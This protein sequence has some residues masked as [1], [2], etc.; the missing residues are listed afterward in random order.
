MGQSAAV[1]IGA[2]ALTVL[3]GETVFAGELVLADAGKTAYSIVVSSAADAGTRAV[4]ED[5]AGILGEMTGATFPVVTDDMPAGDRE[6]VLGADNARLA[7]LGLSGLA[8]GFAEGEYEIRTAGARL[9]IAGAP[10]RGTINGM[11]GF[12]QDHLG[13]RWFTPG[14]QYVPQRAAVKL[15]EIRDRQK[16]A[17]R[18][19]STD[20]AAQ[21]D[22]NW[23]IRNRLNESKAGV[24]GG[25][26]AIA[27]VHGDPRSVGMAGCWRPH[28]LGDVPPLLFGKHP[29]FF[30]ELGGK[31][32]CDPVAHRRA[33]CVTNPEFAQWVAGWTKRKLRGNPQMDF[34]SI[35]HADNPNYCRCDVCQASYEEVGITGTYIRFGNRV[36]EGVAAEFPDA[37]IVTLAYG[38]TFPPT[39]VEVHPNLRVCWCP[40]GA[41]Y[42]HPLDTGGVNRDHDFVGQLKRWQAKSTQLG[43]WYYQY[44]SDNMMPRPMLYPTRRNLQIFRD[45]G[46]DQ[47]FIEMNFNNFKTKETGDG[48]KSVPAYD[49]AD[50]YGWH[51][52]PY[53]LEHVRSYIY[54]RLLWN[55]E[56]DIAA[57]IREFCDVYYGAAGADVNE[58]LTILESLDAYD[59]TMGAAFKAYEGV[60]MSLSQAPRLRWDRTQQLDKLLDEAGE[61]VRDDP[62]LLRRVEMAR[63]PLDLSILVFAGPDDPL[64]AKAFDCF[65][66]TA[67]AIGLK[68]V[69]RT[70]V[71]EPSLAL[72]GLKALMS[73]PTKLVIPGQEP[74]GANVLKNSD[75]E[76][77]IDADGIPD[78]WSAEGRYLPEGYDCD[79][80]GVHSVSTKAYSGT[81]CV[82]LV[83][84]P[85]AM[86]TVS[87]RQRFDVKPGEA[88]RAGIR[89]Q[90]DLKVGGLYMIF[91]AFDKDGTWL[92]HQGG[93]RGVKTTGDRWAELTSDNTVDDRTAQLM[94]EVLIYDDRAEGR[95]WIDDFECARIEK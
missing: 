11:Y 37:R 69:K 55:P 57:G 39:P 75:F 35:T 67:E 84:K 47:V 5:L 7:I 34:V 56:F 59:K 31:R 42:V 1:L 29:E 44:Q 71:S 65:F 21:W 46:V 78:G 12:L 53:G 72:A 66:G 20:S 79:P 76:T 83:K 60:H 19:R 51:T 94:V 24:A 28:A 89:Y 48:D 63:M 2:A 17:F 87:L 95:A 45:L 15:G 61:K 9:V 22:A 82:Q 18:W 62:M 50:R 27:Q 68:S 16:P 92:Y 90:S 36:A 93:V 64:R 13:C 32:V 91:T 3:A 88:W 10:R 4:A 85:A 26:S 70:A 40:I 8:E 80:A 73:D 49:K 6:I 77:D 52:F 54:A 33:Y 30:C 81:Y 25:A 86:S 43:I 23:V 74:V 58:Y 41:D 14:C 38:I